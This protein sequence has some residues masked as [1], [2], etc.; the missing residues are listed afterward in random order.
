MILFQQSFILRVKTKLSAS[1]W[2]NLITVAYIFLK[3]GTNHNKLIIVSIFYGI[4][5]CL[6][7][8]SKILL[9]WFKKKNKSLLIF[10]SAL[11]FCSHF[12]A[13]IVS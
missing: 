2:I 4:Y 9:S 3:V 7:Y 10:I 8:H 11:W 6:Y 13:V 5:F 1:T 12:K